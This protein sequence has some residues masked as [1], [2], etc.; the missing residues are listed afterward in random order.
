MGDD[1][2]IYKY[3]PTA[4]TVRGPWGGKDREATVPK[5]V[6]LH[7]LSFHVVLLMRTLRA[8]R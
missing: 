5:D 2:Q 1:L 6:E 8:H 7:Y 3:Q 4:H